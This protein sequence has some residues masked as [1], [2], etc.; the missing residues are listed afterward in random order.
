MKLG[1]EQGR[2]CCVRLGRRKRRKR[3]ENEKELLSTERVERKKKEEKRNGAFGQNN[4]AAPF[5]FFLFYYDYFT[6]DKVKD[7]ISFKANQW[8]TRGKRIP[9][10]FSKPSTLINCYK[11]PLC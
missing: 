11:T 6:K 9:N 4:G 10:L 7:E 2:G 3:K 5:F 1:Q 8:L